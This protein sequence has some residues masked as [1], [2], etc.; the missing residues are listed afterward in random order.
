MNWVP[1]GEITKTHGL[2]GEVKLKP[3]VIDP[4]LI[5]GVH[6]ARLV[7]EGQE[8]VE[9]DLEKVRGQGGRWI[10]KFKDCKTIEQARERIGQTLEIFRESFAPLPEGEYYWF[11]IEGLQVFDESGRPYGTV[12]EIIHTGSNDVYVVKDGDKE[13][14]LPM[15]DSVVKVI[16]LKENTLIFHIVEGLLENYPV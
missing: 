14:L 13:L 2:K 16:D 3:V 5:Y 8:P 9:T 10:V 15:I 12:T 6:K 4:S 7:G 1:V 11:Q